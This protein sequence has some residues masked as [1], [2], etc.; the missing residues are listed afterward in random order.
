MRTTGHRALGV[1]LSMVLMSSVT[2]VPRTATADAVDEQTEAL[3]ELQAELDA[4]FAPAI[5]SDR[6]DL[7]AGSF[8]A[9]MQTASPA[10]APVIVTS[11]ALVEADATIT[12]EWADVLGI[13]AFEVLRD[14]AVVAESDGTAPF[15]DTVAAGR[16]YEYEVRAIDPGAG[17]PIVG[18]TTV[19]VPAADRGC[20]LTWTG[21]ADSE[22]ADPDNW[23]PIGVAPG[24]PRTPK[25]GDDVCIDVR[26]NTPA[27]SSDAGAAVATA[28]TTLTADKAAPALLDIAAGDFTVSTQFDNVDL[29]IT[30]GVFASTGATSF[31]LLNVADGEL[32]LSD[33]TTVSGG[34]EFGPGTPLVRSTD[35]SAV[36]FDVARS[37][38]DDATLTL[39]GAVE[40]A[41]IQL[42]MTGT[43]SVEPS[44]DGATMT[45]APFVPSGTA[46]ID[47]SMS[48][49]M[50]V[51]DGAALTVTDHQAIAA[52]V[53]PPLIFVDGTLTL[54]Q[55]V[56]QLGNVDLFGTGS[57]I[58]LNGGSNVFAGLEVIDDMTLDDGIAIDV[59][60]DLQ[61]RSLSLN[62]GATF[63]VGGVL[64]YTSFLVLS[65]ATIT[66][67]TIITTGTGA[68][69]GDIDVFG[70]ANRIVG[71]ITTNGSIRLA[72]DPE[73]GTDAK[74][75]ID[76]GLTLGPDALVDTSLTGS[77]VTGRLAVRDAVALDG[78]LLARITGVIPADTDVA[79][80]SWGSATGTIVA[81]ISGNTDATTI[82]Q[83]T[84][85]VFVRRDGGGPGL[86]VTAV[87]ALGMFVDAELGSQVTVAWPAI[88]DVDSYAVFLDGEQVDETSATTSVVNPGDLGPG[89]EVSVSVVAM[90][91]EDEIDVGSV[92]FVL[93]VR[94]CSMT[95]TGAINADWS[96]PLNWLPI[97]TETM[98]SPRVTDSSDDVCV[99][100]ATNTPVIIDGDVSVDS[101]TSKLSSDE[102]AVSLV[103]DVVKGDVVAV[104]VIDLTTL[105]VRQGSVTTAALTVDESTL[106]N[107]VVDATVGDL[108]VVVVN[109]VGGGSNDA[110]ILG[111]VSID[112]VVQSADT[113]LRIEDLRS[114]G[115]TVLD[116]LGPTTLDKQVAALEALYLFEDGSLTV[117]GEVTNDL[118]GLTEVGTLT[119]QG[120]SVGLPES[121]VIG[122]L[123]VADSDLD[124]DG[125]VTVTGQWSL[126]DGSLV[127]IGGDLTLGPDAKVDVTSTDGDEFTFVEI[128]GTANLDGSL[129]IDV[130]EQVTGL[131]F[132]QWVGFTGSFD[133]TA[134]SGAGSTDT[135]LIIDD[136]GISIEPVVT[137][138]PELSVLG[139]DVGDGLGAVDLLLSWPAVDDA[140]SYAV[141]RNG[142]LAVEVAIPIAD[143]TSD[144]KQTDT[145]SVIALDD[146]G[147]ELAD[148]GS[149]DVLAAVNGCDVVWT[150]AISS[151]WD[152][153][154]NWAP[155]ISGGVVPPQ[156]APGALDLVCVL[157][158]ENLPISVTDDVE[159]GAVF[160]LL[161]SNDGIGLGD[162]VIA[163]DVS[164]ASFETV[165][166]IITSGVSADGAALDPG[167]VFTLSGDLVLDRSA[168]VLADDLT[169][170]GAI[171]VHD[172]ES[173][174]DVDAADPITVSADLLAISD[175]NL[176]I[177]SDVSLSATRVE[178]D[179]GGAAGGTALTA[180][181]LVALGGDNGVVGAGTSFS[182]V[183]V[184]P[185]ARLVAERLGGV[186]GTDFIVGG[187]LDLLG[188]GGELGS[189]LVDGADAEVTV[190]GGPVNVMTEIKTIGE[191]S[192]FGASLEVVD[193]LTT[194]RTVLFSGDLSVGDRLDTAQVYSLGTSAID[195]PELDIVADPEGIIDSGII[196]SASADDPVLA[197]TGD[198]T[199]RADAAVR[200][201]L[202]V[203]P[204]TPLIEV[205][206]SV[207]LAGDV[208]VAV[209]VPVPA[210]TEQ[211]LITWSAAAGTLATTLTGDGADKGQL[212]QR[213]DG[214]YLTS[215]D[216]EECSDAPRFADMNVDGCWVDQ[217][218]GTYTADQADNVDGVTIGGVDIAVLDDDTTIRI[219]PDA[220]QISTIDAGGAPVPVAIS[221]PVSDDTAVLT[222]IPLG[223]FT[224]DDFEIGTS[225][226]FAFDELLGFP[227][228]GTPTLVSGAGG[229]HLQ[230]DL[231]LTGILRTVGSLDLSIGDLGI[232]SNDLSLEN[233]SAVFADLA[234]IV[235][236]DIDWR[237]ASTWDFSSLGLNGPSITGEVDFDELDGGGTLSVRDLRVDDVL[238]LPDFDLT[239]VFTATAKTWTVEQPT[240]S[241][242]RS[243]SFAYTPEGA[244][245]SAE[246]LLGDAEGESGRTSAATWGDWLDVDGF[247]LAWSLAE[248]RWNIAGRLTDPEVA[249]TGSYS[250]NADG[251]TET[252]D[253]DI[254][255][256]ELGPFATFDL[257]LAFDGSGDSD[258]Y[259]A[260]AVITRDGAPP[261]DGG[262]VFTF[263]DGDLSTASL[264]F[265]SIEIG[266]L[267]TI[268]DFAFTYNGE[269]G[270]FGLTG[271]LVQPG[272]ADNSIDG[273]LT[274]DDG[275]LSAG[276]LRLDTLEIGPIR[277]DEFAFVFTRNAGDERLTTA[278]VTGNVQAGSRDVT[279]VGGSITFAD[280]AITEFE[281]TVG[282]IDLGGIAQ[283][284]EASFSYT[285]N[286]DGTAVIGG[287]GRLITSDGTTDT[288]VLVELTILDGQVVDGRIEADVLSFARAIEIE[289]F[290]LTNRPLTPGTCS[291]FPAPAGA[292]Q[293]QVAGQTTSNGETTSVDGC[294]VI[295]GPRLV[296]GELD[297]GNL[298][299]GGLL[300]IEALTASFAQEVDVEVPGPDGN[301]VT[302]SRT[303]MSLSATARVGEGPAKAFSGSASFADGGLT[304]LSLALPEIDLMNI[305]KLRDVEFSYIGST[306]WDKDI[307]TTFNLSGSVV[308]ENTT[309]SFAGDIVFGDDGEVEELL[310]NAED[311]DFGV[312]RLDLLSFAYS[313]DGDETEWALA[314][315][316]DVAGQTRSISG[317]ATVENG[318][319]V[320]ADLALEGIVIADLAVIDNIELSY[321]RETDGSEE[322]SGSAAI[323]TPDGKSEAVALGFAF[324]AD[325]SLVAGF[326]EISRLEWSELFAF[327]DLRF[328]YASGP[329][330]TRWDVSGSTTLEG[331]TTSLSGF[332]ELEAG[333]ATAG[334]LV[335]ENLRIGA[336]ATIE[337]L[338]LSAEV[339]GDS[340]VWSATII[341][342]NADRTTGSGSM[343]WTDGRLTAAQLEL[344]DLRFSELFI[345]SDLSIS[346]TS[347]EWLLSAQFENKGENNEISTVLG[348]DDGRLVT[349]A[350]TIRQLSFGDVLEIDE[351][352]LSYDS[353][354]TGTSWRSSGIVTV[355]DQT[356]SMAASFGFEG[357]Q[358]QSAQITIGRLSWGGA[359]ALEDVTFTFDRVA[360]GTRWALDGGIVISGETTSL[361]GFMEFDQ[362]RLV[363]GDLTIT[364][365]RFGP[366]ATIDELSLT[367]QA[368]D[369]GS[370]F[371]A[372]IT[373][374]DGGS[375]GG[376]MV[377][378]DGRLD[379]ASLDLSDLRFSGTFSVFDA[380]MNYDAGNW[381]FDAFF[382]SDGNEVSI[383][384]GLVFVDGRL[385]DGTLSVGDVRLAGFSLTDFA[386]VLGDSIDLG[387]GP[388]SI[389]DVCDV[390]D[391]GGSGGVYGISASIVNEAGDDGT[392]AGRLRVD[393][394]ALVDGVVCATNIDIGEI[395][396]IDELL[397]RAT[398]E[399]AGDQVRDTW[400]GDVELRNAAEPDEPFEGSFDWVVLDGRT[401]SV[402][403][404]ASEIRFSDLLVVEDVSFSYDR[405][406]DGVRWGIGAAL[407]RPNS[408]P[409]VSGF[410][411]LAEGRV[412]AASITIAEVSFGN[413]VSLN[414][415]TM[416]W[417]GRRAVS[418]PPAQ[419]FDNDGTFTSIPV[420]GCDETPDGSNVPSGPPST[421]GAEAYFR[422]DAQV[423]AGAS[424]VGAAGSI[425]FVDGKM[426]MFDVSI[427]C[428]NLGDWLS[429][430]DVRVGVSDQGDY[431]FQAAQSGATEA[432]Q[433][434]TGRITMDEG[435]VA[436]GR[437][438]AN[439][440]SLG[441]VELS[442]LRLTLGQQESGLSEWGAAVATRD[443]DG[444]GDIDFDGSVQLDDGRVVG[445]TLGFPDLPLLDFVPVEGV[446]LGF[447]R[448]DND[449]GPG[450]GNLRL[451][452]AATIV[453]P[454][455]SDGGELDLLLVWSDG[456]LVA[457]SLRADDIELF[458]VID[459]GSLEIAYNRNALGGPRWAGTMRTDVPGQSGSSIALSFDVINGKLDSGFIGFDGNGDG[460]PDGP[461]SSGSAP[462]TGN[463]ELGG[464]PLKALFLR[465]CSAETTS[466]FCA[467]VNGPEWFGQLKVQLPTGN[468]P[469]LDAEVTI[470]NGRFVNASMDL[471]FDPG[472]MI[473]SGV[474]LDS[475][476]A[477]LELDPRL[478]FCG[479]L[480]A[481]VGSSAI[482]IAR[483]EGGFEF[484]EGF[485]GINS[486]PRSCDEPPVPFNV[487]DGAEADYYRFLIEAEATLFP[488]NPL[489]I[490]LSGTGYLDLWTSGYLGLGAEINAGFVGDRIVVN[491]EVRGSVFNTNNI[492][493]TNPRTGQPLTG[494]HAQL[495]TTAGVTVLNKT[496]SARFLVNTVGWSGCARTG[497]AGT[498]VGVSGYWNGNGFA[499]SCRLGRVEIIVPGTTTTGAFIGA[500]LTADAGV[501]PSYARLL[502]ITPTADTLFDVGPGE[503]LL[504]LVMRS[505][506]GTPNT[507]VISPTG[508]V[509]DVRSDFGE[510]GPITDTGDNDQIFILENPA[511]GTWTVRQV[512]GSPTLDAVETY[513]GLPDVDVA[514]TLHQAGGELSFDYSLVEVAGQGVS[515]VERDSNGATINLVGRVETEV[516]SPTS[517]GLQREDVSTT[518]IHLES[519]VASG[520]RSGTFTY[521]T[522]AAAAGG[523]HQLVALVEQD[524]LPREEVVLATYVVAPASTAVAPT[525]VTA[526]ATSDGATVSWEPPTDD[527][528]RQITAYHVSSERGFIMAVDADA[529]SAELP[530]PMM[531]PGETLEVYVQAF[532]ARGPGITGVG[533]FEATAT[534]G[535][536]YDQPVQPQSFVVGSD[537]MTPPDTTPVLG[538]NSVPTVV[539]PGTSV[540]PPVDPTPDP[541]VIPTNQLPSTG[542]SITTL[543][544]LAAMLTL[545]G[546]AIRLRSRRGHRRTASAILASIG[547]AS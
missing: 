502:G 422:I 3:R 127:E 462:A 174:L 226:P 134:L 444:G 245:V 143:V 103:I 122:D 385:V 530:I 218:D 370:R 259:I 125:N 29:A 199:L 22:F 419:R 168:V 246:I 250:T 318:R 409:S 447:E 270:R 19:A 123:L 308:G 99:D 149:L 179:N 82:E 115:D 62:N 113:T 109:T 191:L 188:P 87:A 513:L 63:T 542:G 371:D 77:D 495:S 541:P 20:D 435:R 519:L 292:Q 429:L 47:V 524:G 145:W 438:S 176:L 83:K 303:D 178:L 506:A 101:I 374:V 363:A 258:I 150:G 391:P 249:F 293:W 263:D 155:V 479:S 357:G 498:E 180:T 36:R 61:I 222:T 294:L 431:L 24:A 491:G 329:D 157:A 95:W 67:P 268:E 471:T 142:D 291:S 230:V 60:N 190:N 225:I 283:I 487:P 499:L 223:I 204:T 271:D 529:R 55:P 440:L 253:L 189:L 186:A 333:R 166:E 514:A 343:T 117:D 53:R 331:E 355:G 428:L 260:T 235:D 360:S 397:L 158:D 307:D 257:D 457:G 175:A 33:N 11:V 485:S 290:T 21:A 470:R 227:V 265:E 364:N 73:V 141:L 344:A 39:D 389:A 256:A 507:Q 212:R 474:F 31:R 68:A 338:S 182:E 187:R 35:G 545:L 34:V 45:L 449:G 273:S 358:L 261:I 38:I 28:S 362:G 317:S 65:S 247:E 369:T 244:P 356:T 46:Q 124:A 334:E 538:P 104:D 337:Q 275:K 443:P 74:L 26:T 177:A 242:L 430:D 475:I 262:G 316:V 170:G 450:D 424:A 439:N 496:A 214:L 229:W 224:F 58:E 27:T 365:L 94:D 490:D 547:E 241:R 86:D 284:V 165:G 386:L 97:S 205:A 32:A 351:F 461:N 525:A 301:K 377:W 320:R 215:G 13:G 327:E 131:P 139:F 251:E 511:A 18:I 207:A 136:D 380:A 378:V 353:S 209:V 427:S 536:M 468:A 159:A 532:T 458:D 163:I 44:G 311:I 206:G 1:C 120:T 396:T 478:R 459:G 400:S 441:F 287:E 306:P 404:A 106:G 388:E 340:T 453:G 348:F 162:D 198:L 309:S 434:V 129:T 375:A 411:D 41:G 278:T 197:I 324:D 349:A 534:T 167:G 342:D 264:T 138:A 15:V 100:I 110:E 4:L 217:G 118:V 219:D 432:N 7:G 164:G 546:L 473:F 137:G 504:G 313:A 238:V 325:G 2:G 114:P 460:I 326:V 195:A 445:G 88:A 484:S 367:Y 276:E 171:R 169:V 406:T 51:V 405:T 98:P 456:T 59:P 463:G 352:I 366:L 297:L 285:K 14:G 56:T 111:A 413:V 248:K 346:L 423:G 489:G 213:A 543:L 315:L 160:S 133:A 210:G 328:D 12:L 240:P 512:P 330:S 476:G 181:T 368:G 407:R 414:D 390:P 280:G 57:A 126:A 420:G 107:A 78:A 472:I 410:I 544:A 535:P 232:R 399:V 412:V 282:A 277:F 128:F 523:E 52:E 69:D 234:A 116:L 466:T 421:T 233:L 203:I 392:F 192:L 383:S 500:G 522:N 30:G 140:A 48:G 372:S 132:I 105:T 183:T 10:D 208:D 274:F 395:I 112:R 451:S 527:G 312:F 49:P 335:I 486:S 185:G 153:P 310:I 526:S 345:L 446:T 50:T 119:M 350:L 398:T 516:P 93:P 515:F 72:S 528:G 302:I 220:G 402:E 448:I 323:T 464:F 252:F 510:E 482:P 379:R 505:A 130:A 281:L 442:S 517:A 184:D 156:A 332:L 497:V 37:T 359:I 465:Y 299:I 508:T 272:G 154:L 493:T 341:I 433:S 43:S 221:V 416:T 266:E 228:A 477:D 151:A 85:G 23:A 202:D 481:T 347:E 403:I 146:G 84:G 91:G 25:A 354:G 269:E 503:E 75:A 254:D 279:P 336:L 305:V 76:G 393:D 455:G 295:D 520:R 425:G 488:G 533:T 322:W 494:V 492:P 173:A 483:I 243:I 286:A 537:P 304:A 193:A 509:Y 216:V 89:D 288:P 373:F 239:G 161:Q 480:G 300:T 376:F 426:S 319:V 54:T 469:S 108:G 96:N 80:I 387:G 152:D 467:D 540:D 296:A 436:G 17:N 382:T 70:T 539:D 289:N 408:S 267:A 437:L 40:L 135:E 81:T 531:T 8:S 64:D 401:R 90:V 9:P 501:S 314:G 418:Q 5:G 237:N 339:T 452:G 231:D 211:P 148:M 454:G 384:G 518:P 102:D 16:S 147:S 121:T 321:S 298:R 71:D 196:T 417:V 394:G 521:R 381:T 255:G 236:L 42:E 194:R 361:S 200:L 92:E 201:A 79:A 415:F 66:A 6:V 144:A 172:D